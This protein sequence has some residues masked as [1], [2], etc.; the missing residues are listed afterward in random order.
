MGIFLEMFQVDPI[1]KYNRLSC[2]SHR[3]DESKQKFFFSYWA[4]V[5]GKKKK[6]KE[7][8]KGHTCTPVL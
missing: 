4:E 6:N 5:Q 3:T 2:I 8:K 7:K 1:L